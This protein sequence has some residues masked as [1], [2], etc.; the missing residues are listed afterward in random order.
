MKLA[1]VEL[2]RNPEK[3]WDGAREKPN[4]LCDSKTEI[5]NCSFGCWTSAPDGEHIAY[6]YENQVKRLNG[7]LEEYVKNNHFLR[8]RMSRFLFFP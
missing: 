8:F 2:A 4:S 7:I 1:C 5:D 3:I 6:F